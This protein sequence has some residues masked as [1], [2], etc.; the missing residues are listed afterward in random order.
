MLGRRGL[1]A[2][3]TLVLGCGRGDPTIDSPA[4][5]AA[6]ASA[7]PAAASDAGAI[8]A[9]TFALFDAYPRL[10]RDLA[11]TELGRFPSPL[12]NARSLDERVWIK[13]DDDFTRSPSCDP[14]FALARLFGGGKVR[15]LEL[16]LGE[17]RARGKRRLVT[18]GGVGSNQALA[19]ALLGPPLGFSVRVH[20]APQPRS[21]LTAANLAGDAASHAEML[22]FDTVTEAHARALRD[23]REDADTYV[24]SP[25]GTTPLGTLGFVSAGLELAEDVRAGRL[26]A[27]R[28]IYVALGLGGTAAGLA[29]GCALAGLSTEIVAVR[30]SSPGS[31]SAATLRT[32]YDPILPV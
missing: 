18:S 8:P 27:P 12:E 30:V 19:V 14:S 22:L 21:S 9:P 15:K 13:R 3:S 26:P 17:A 10:A 16:F 5:V 20:L 29:L 7:P 4:R 11:R 2:G 25:G 23:A 32:V 6:P 31:V 24:V 28:R 1:L